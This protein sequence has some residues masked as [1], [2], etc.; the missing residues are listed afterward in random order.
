MR[1]PIIWLPMSCL[2]FACAEPQLGPDSR[3]EPRFTEAAAP[4]RMNAA[5]HWN[6]VARALVIKN[7]SNPY[8]AVRGYA[9]VGIAQYNAASAVD[10][11]PRH[12]PSAFVRAAITRA[13]V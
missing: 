10:N 9:L 2:A 7:A 1:F 13:S 11:S 6:E 8:S 12:R 3:T 4:S 5:A